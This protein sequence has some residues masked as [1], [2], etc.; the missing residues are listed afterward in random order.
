MSAAT[1]LGYI[2]S[3]LWVIAEIVPSIASYR[4]DKKKV[5][6]EAVAAMRKALNKTRVFLRKPD[7][8]NTDELTIISELWNEASMKVGIVDPQVGRIL[9][10]KSRFWSDHKLFIDLGKDNEIISLND[11][12]SEIDKLYDKM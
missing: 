2:G 9:G 11:V 1:I 8:S 12:I 5:Q 7:F 6:N 10:D 4:L 3:Q